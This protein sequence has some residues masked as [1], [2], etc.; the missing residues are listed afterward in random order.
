MVSKF[1]IVRKQESYIALE[2]RNMTV[3]QLMDKYNTKQLEKLAIAGM[4][5][6]QNFPTKNALATEMIRLSNIGWREI[7]EYDENDPRQYKVVSAL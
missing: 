2:P 4:L 5:D 6:P 7:D 3:D 1:R